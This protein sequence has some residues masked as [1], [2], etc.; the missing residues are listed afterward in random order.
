MLGRR[1]ARLGTLTTIALLLAGCAR[2]QPTTQVAPK[3]KGPEIRKKYFY[4]NRPYGSEAQFNPL[5]SFL[6]NGY[7]QV[8]TGSNRALFEFDYDK[9]TKTVWNSIARADVIIKQ[10]GVKDWLRFEVFPLSSKTNGGGQWVPNYQLHLFAGGTNYIR[11][12]SWFEQRDVAHPRIAAMSTFVLQ[13]AMNE[14]VENTI[15]TQGSVDATT[16]LLIFDPAALLLW[17]SDRVQRFV[18]SRVEFTEWPGQVSFGL[19]GESIENTFETTMVRFRSARFPNWRV[20]TT[21]GGSYLGGISRRGRDSTWWTLGAGAEAIDNPVIDTVTFRRTANFVG[22]L[23]LFVDKNGS[24]LGS[25]IVKPAFD[26]GATLNVYPGVIRIGTWS[27][28]FWVAWLR[29][30]QLRLGIST[31]WGVGVNRNPRPVTRD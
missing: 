19:P 16:D 3:L 2:S 15:L 21:M 12:M 7:D 31:K 28:G 6:N 17:N 20:M 22:N 30:E 29:T 13:H 14:L 27:P 18:G 5:T 10:Y 1:T 9:G 4:A 26:A 24:L 25:F 8:R 11:L 23:G